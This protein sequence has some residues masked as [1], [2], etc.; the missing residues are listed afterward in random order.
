M[1]GPPLHP[2]PD[3]LEHSMKTKAN[4]KK[5]GPS[6]TCY[7]VNHSPGKLP[8][9]ILFEKTDG[10]CCLVP[11]PLLCAVEFSGNDTV[12][13]HFASGI[14]TVHGKNLE[15]LSEP[16]STFQLERVSETKKPGAAN[17]VWVSELLFAEIVQ[18]GRATARGDQVALKGAPFLETT[19]IG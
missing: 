4:R 9:C 12:K 2:D 19:R 16:V 15:R 17:S 11:Y 18:E 14:I 6:R 3:K 13:F 10:T 8:Q 1:D 7:S 5:S